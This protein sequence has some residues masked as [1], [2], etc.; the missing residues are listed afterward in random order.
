MGYICDA[1][2]ASVLVYISICVVYVD[3]N[4]TTNFCLRPKTENAVLVRIHG[5]KMTQ[6]R[7]PARVQVC[8]RLGLGIG[9]FSDTFKPHAK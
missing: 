7:F 2:L 8:T 5:T 3:I 1:C 6:A 4:I 9:E